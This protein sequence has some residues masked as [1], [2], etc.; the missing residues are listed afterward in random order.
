MEE[1][2]IVLCLQILHFVYG[3]N[4]SGISYRAENALFSHRGIC[5]VCNCCT[6][7]PDTPEVGDVPPSGSAPPAPPKRSIMRDVLLVYVWREGWITM[8]GTSKQFFRT[9]RFFPVFHA[10]LISSKKSQRFLWLFSGVKTFVFVKIT[11]GIY[12]VKKRL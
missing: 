11:Y 8:C 1:L 3:V 10:R 7:P 4:K 12:S 6:E 9:Q 5:C 2:S